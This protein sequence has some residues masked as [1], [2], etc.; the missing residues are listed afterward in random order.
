MRTTSGFRA[1]QL[2]DSV[3]ERVG[4]NCR[5]ACG[6]IK[7]NTLKVQATYSCCIANYPLKRL[8][9]STTAEKEMR[10]AID[11]VSQE[12]KTYCLHS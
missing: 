2:A 8:E 3:Q 1:E 12:D 7:L 11:E 10:N 6:K 5:G 4:S 9:T